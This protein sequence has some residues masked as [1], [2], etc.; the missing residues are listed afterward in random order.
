MEERLCKLLEI[1]L[2]SSSP[3]TRSIV[4]PISSG[5][6]GDV[7][8]FSQAGSLGIVVSSEGQ[9]SVRRKLQLSRDTRTQF[10]PYPISFLPY[11]VLSYLTV[12]FLGLPNTSSDSVCSARGP[13][14][15][16]ESKMITLSLIQ[17][18][19]SGIVEAT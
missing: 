10:L 8:K 17:Q 13:T 15:S 11:L 19:N 12:A 4:M 14:C 18:S 16:R 7:T 5:P 9:C 3:S 2:L 6:G 1:L